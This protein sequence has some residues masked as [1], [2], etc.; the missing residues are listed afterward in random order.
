MLTR[1]RADRLRGIV[2]TAVLAR[3]PSVSAAQEQ[4]PASICAESLQCWGNTKMGSSSRAG[5]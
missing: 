3:S 1:R 2:P 4:F 5:T